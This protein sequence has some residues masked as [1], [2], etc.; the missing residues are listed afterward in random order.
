[1]LETVF[2]VEGR[3]P[4]ERRVVDEEWFVLKRSIWHAVERRNLVSRDT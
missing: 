4:L 2:N 3:G 1:M